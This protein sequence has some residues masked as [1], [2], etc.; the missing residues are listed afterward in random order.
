[1]FLG[2]GF[3][4]FLLRSAIFRYQLFFECY[5]G[6]A[7]LTAL[8]HLAAALHSILLAGNYLVCCSTIPKYK[9]EN[10]LSKFISEINWFSI[11]WS[12]K[13]GILCSVSGSFWFA[14]CFKFSIMSPE[15][16]TFTSELKRKS[17]ITHHNTP[18]AAGSLETFCIWDS[19][20][21]D[22]KYVIQK[23][24]YAFVKQYLFLLAPWV[25][26]FCASFSWLVYVCAVLIAHYTS[27]SSMNAI[28]YLI[29]Y[30]LLSK[31]I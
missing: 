9:S 4:G 5:R 15:N 30:C 25:V 20:L 22:C 14:A 31:D 19:V 26:M 6:V 17:I 2:S 18:L 11:W 28:G 24:S 8:S 29:W 16:S 7:F 13:K 1:M 27:W 23:S 10:L 12:F 21:R 3:Y